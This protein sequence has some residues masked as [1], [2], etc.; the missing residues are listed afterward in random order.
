MLRTSHCLLLLQKQTYTGTPDRSI[1]VD[2][3]S[4]LRQIHFLVD[5]PLAPLRP[6]QSSVPNRV[7]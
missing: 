7:Q 2:N 6:S 3:P 5:Q 4:G 1:H